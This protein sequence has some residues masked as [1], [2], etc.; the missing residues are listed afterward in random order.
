[1]MMMMMMMT[2]GEQ[3]ALSW[4]HFDACRN[5]RFLLEQLNDSVESTQMAA[6]SFPHYQFRIFSLTPI[7]VTPTTT[8]C[9]S[10]AVADSPLGV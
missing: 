2:V 9:F 5:H 7:S 8:D 1:M 6:L 4:R 3:T 10:S